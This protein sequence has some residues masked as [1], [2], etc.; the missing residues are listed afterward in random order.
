M[1]T[2]GDEGAAAQLVEDVWPDA[3]RIAL[4]VTGEAGLAE[5]AAQEACVAMLLQLPRLR[6][7]EAFA[8][9]F[10][11]IVTRSAVRQLRAA[12]RTIPVAKM[13]EHATPANEGSDLRYLL[14]HLPP[15][16]RLALLL[17]YHHGFTSAEIGSICGVPAGTIRYRI[18]RAR[19]RLR[20]LMM[21]KSAAEGR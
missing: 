9:W 10:G 20:A 11:R 2:G 12:S 18:W 1:V 19:R 4:S 8:T 6:H 15:P 5:D 17:H 16:E 7:P 14:E 13:P 21:D 3:Y